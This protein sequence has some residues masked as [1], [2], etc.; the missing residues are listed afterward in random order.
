M[1]SV[2]KEIILAAEQM[3]I[4]LEQNESSKKHK[5]QYWQEL[6]DLAEGH[7]QIVHGLDAHAVNELR[8]V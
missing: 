1:G 4:P 7:V 6:W 3:E 8:I 5:R 2:A